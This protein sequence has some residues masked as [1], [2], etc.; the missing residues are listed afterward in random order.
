VLPTPTVVVPITGAEPAPFVVKRIPRL[1]LNEPQLYEPIEARAVKLRGLR[2]TL[3]GCT[4][5][6]QKQVRK[7]SV[8]TAYAKPLRKRAVAAIAAS[9]C[10]SSS[11]VQ[12][13]PDV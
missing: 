9:V 4:A 1:A 2:D 10:A 12:A 8:L 7:H 5:A 3:G 6:L 11:P 13:G